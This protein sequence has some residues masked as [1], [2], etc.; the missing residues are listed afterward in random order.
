MAIEWGAGNR[1]CQARLTSPFNDSMSLVDK[2]NSAAVMDV[3][4]ASGL[5]PPHILIKKA[6]Y[7]EVHII[8]RQCINKELPGCSVC[9]CVLFK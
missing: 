2:G 3:C 4:T 5:V 8:N 1:S 6:E 7:N 9:N